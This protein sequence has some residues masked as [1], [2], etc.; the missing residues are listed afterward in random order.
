[1]KKLYK[2]GLAIIKRKKLL[3][4]RDFDEDVFIMPGGCVK[5]GESAEKCLLREIKEELGVK[6]SLN[7]LKFLGNFKCVTP[8]GKNIIEEDV[9]LGKIK[10]KIKPQSEIAE[11]EWIDSNCDKNKLSPL[12]RFHILPKLIEEGFVK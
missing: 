9:Y 11:V 12:L 6:V 4:C 7:S 5:L 8:D 10:G 3:V 1:M 2:I